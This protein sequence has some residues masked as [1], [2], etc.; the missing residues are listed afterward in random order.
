MGQ[1]YEQLLR[2]QGIDVS[3]VD[4]LV[5]DPKDLT[6]I[7]DPEHPGVAAF[8]SVGNAFMVDPQFAGGPPTMTG[9]SRLRLT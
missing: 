8:N 3:K 7:T 5:F 6:R 9:T 4:L 1:R 2:Q